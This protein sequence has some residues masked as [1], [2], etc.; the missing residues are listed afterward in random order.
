MFWTG[1]SLNPFRSLGPAIVEGLWPDYFW[2][3]WVGPIAGG[4]LAVVFYKLIKALEYETIHETDEPK[5]QEPILP[6]ARDNEVQENAKLNSI[7]VGDSQP[8]ARK[9]VPPPPKEE[10][11]SGLP[12]ADYD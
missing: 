5:S 2:I 6:T 9:A 1:A 4:L 7:Q 12:S 8:K 11:T 10:H 3:Y